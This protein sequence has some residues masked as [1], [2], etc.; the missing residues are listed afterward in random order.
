MKLLNLFFVFVWTFSFAQKKPDQKSLQCLV[1]TIQRDSVLV[2]LNDYE[3]AL[4]LNEA[5]QKQLNAEY[6]M[7]KLELETKLKAYGEEQAKLS[8]EQKQTREKE[9]QKMDGELQTFAREAQQKLAQKEQELVAPLNE[10]I[11]KAIEVVATKYGYTHIADKKNFYYV[12][13]TFDVT[14]L[15]VEEANKL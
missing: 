12:S 7:K 1:A 13:A 6:D 14:K 11:A 9:L 15:V 10:K 4:K 5:Y 3:P 2:K 8:E